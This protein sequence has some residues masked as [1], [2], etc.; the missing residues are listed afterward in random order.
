[1]DRNVTQKR[2]DSHLVKGRMNPGEEIGPRIDQTLTQDATGTMVILEFKAMNVGRVRTELTHAAFKQ[3][4]IGAAE[5]HTF[6]N[7]LSTIHH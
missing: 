1:M 6:N 2:I 4:M 7:R 3:I 5:H